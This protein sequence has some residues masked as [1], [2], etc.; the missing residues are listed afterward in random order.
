MTEYRRFAHPGGTWFFTVN[1][2][3]RR[4]NTLLVD[5]IAELRAAFDTVKRRHPFDIDAV[6]ILPDHLHCIW[7][8]PPG[9][10]D[11][12]TRWGL[13]KANFSRRIAREERISASRHQRGERGLWQ[14]R[15]WE[16]LLRDDEDVR[17]HVDYIHWNPVKHG[18]VN[19]VIEWPHSSFHR[20]VNAGVY[21]ADW[22]GGAALD[23]M[24]GE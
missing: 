1:L 14:R 11:Y 16:H 4:G 13:I 19:R 23:V 10:A 20:Y 8:L 18:W 9:D 3:Q 24:A 17:R 21:P 15:F 12:A 5:H 22:G 7:T 6:V 2:A